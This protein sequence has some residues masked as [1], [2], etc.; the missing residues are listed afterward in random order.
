M[1]VY[2]P[3]DIATILQ[4][5]PATLRKYSSLLE[6]YGYE[7]ARNSQRHRYYQD[8]DIITLRNVIAGTNSGDTSNNSEIQE[9][10]Q[11]IKEQSDMIYK[12]NEAME[13]LTKRLDE[14]QEY[15]KN[16]IEERDRK[17]MQTMNEMQEAKK[18]IASDQEEEKP[19][20]FW[21]RLFNR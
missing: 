16:S 14:Q 3:N 17:L 8:K 13:G 19:K 20:G 15:I 12:Q 1:K 11:M 9:L 4:I 7:I 10:K 21:K 18:Q 2:S 5:K 6:K